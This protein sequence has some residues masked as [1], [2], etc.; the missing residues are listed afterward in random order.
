MKLL[1][2]ALASFS[3][4]AADTLEL[5]ARVDARSAINIFILSGSPLGPQDIMVYKNRERQILNFDYY[6]DFGNMVVFSHVDPTDRIIFDTVRHSPDSSL[7]ITAG[8]GIITEQTNQDLIL[9]V[10]PTLLAPHSFIS[11]IY[12]TETDF[13]IYGNYHGISTPAL[14]CPLL[15][16]GFQK[17]ENGKMKSLEFEF[18]IDPSSCDVHIH[19]SEPQSN[20]QIAIFGGR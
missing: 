1:S 3:L 10:D 16:T 11:P 17:L 5:N 8:E 14:G 9:K 13:I 19:F 6:V 2:L 4:F 20:F 12:F 7:S 18:D 15:V